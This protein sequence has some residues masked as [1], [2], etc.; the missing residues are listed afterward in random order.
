MYIEM[1]P[2]QWQES[3]AVLTE[4]SFFSFP[5]LFCSVGQTD[6]ALRPALEE[7]Q[8]MMEKQHNI[9]ETTGHEVIGW[10]NW[11]VQTNKSFVDF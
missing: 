9:L 3:V 5:L 4:H 1:L 11:L 2:T 10:T 6:V 7:W 8:Y